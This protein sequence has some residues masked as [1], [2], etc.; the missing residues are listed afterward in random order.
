MADI[1]APG[2]PRY[3]LARLYGEMAQSWSAQDRR[4]RYY[5]GRHPLAFA[6]PKYRAT[7]GRLFREWSDNWCPVVVDATSE[8]LAIDGFR[9]GEEE[10]ADKDVWDLWQ[11]SY[12]DADSVLAMHEAVKQGEAA[13]IVEPPRPGDKYPRITVEHPSQVIVARAAGDR[14]ERAAALK[15]WLDDDGFIYATVYLSDAVYKFRSSKGVQDGLRSVEPGAIKWIER[16]GEAHR[17][18]H[19]FGCVPVVPLRNN[20]TML[21]G[22]Q[23]DLDPVIPIQNAINKLATDMLVASEYAAFPQRWATGIEIPTD[24]EGQPIDSDTFLSFIG[25]VWAVEDPDARFGDFTVSDL[26]P[27]IAG[28]EMLIQHLAAQ[29]RTPPHYL[30]GQSGAFPSGESLKATETGLVAKVKGRQLHYGEGW[31]E[32]VRLALLAR[33]DASSRAK[34]QARDTETIWRDPESRTMGEVT[35]SALKLKELEVPRKAL[36]ERVGASQTEIRRWDSQ[37]QA[38]ALAQEALLYAGARP[39]DQG[40]PNQTPT[41][42]GQTPQPNGG[43]QPSGGAANAR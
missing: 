33:G 38:E 9:F 26:R 27:Y 42:P 25:R 8:R 12:M 1:P 16:P 2:T 39:T 37:A 43:G 29:T 5:E 35:D 10:E 32:V 40:L 19:S 30:L 15:A 11:H 13:A 21:G 6:T 14:R 23:S 4:E 20:P 41:T 18:A 28:I 24:D 22:G 34:A 7:F 31:E 36:W 3:W 17:V